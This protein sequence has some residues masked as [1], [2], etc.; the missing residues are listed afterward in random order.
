MGEYGSTKTRF[1]AYAVAAVRAWI[2]VGEIDISLNFFLV[3]VY[4]SR[5]RK[6]IKQCEKD[7][8]F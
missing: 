3:K 2:S 4:R 5:A 1:L 8:R 6:K 7:L